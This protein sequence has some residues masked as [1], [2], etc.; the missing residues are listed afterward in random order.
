[1]KRIEV[2]GDSF[3]RGQQP[4][5]LVG[6]NYWP[7]SSPGCA[8]GGSG[9]WS[10]IQNYDSGVVEREIAAM[11]EIGANTLRVW[12]GYSDAHWSAANNL[13]REGRRCLAHLLDTCDRNG[14]YV[15]PT[16]GGAGTRWG[17]KRGLGNSFQECPS[18]VYTDQ[19]VEEQFLADILTLME[20]SEMGVRENVLAID[21][22][23]E[24]VFGIPTAKLEKVDATWAFGSG[25][26]DF[27]GSLRI[28]SAVTAWERWASNAWGSKAAAAA[29]FELKGETEDFPIPRAADFLFPGHREKLAASYQL[30]VN[31]C[32]NQHGIRMGDAIRS[33]YPQMLVTI[34]LGCGGTG[35]CFQG[36][37][38][39]E[40][41]QVMM[42]TQNVR[43][44]QDGLDF[45]CIHLYHSHGTD[46]SRMSFLRHF[47]GSSRPV[48]I[49][50]FAHIPRHIDPETGTGT[51]A[52]Q[53]A[54]AAFWDIVLRGT[55]RYNFAGALGCIY[56]DIDDDPFS[57]G[58]ACLGI[59]TRSGEPKRAHSIFKKWASSK[60]APVDCHPEPIP[61]DPG[62]YRN[63]VQMMGELYARHTNKETR[64]T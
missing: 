25:D 9:D 64:K 59:T 54:Q 22:A 30:F 27:E 43:E 8:P 12:F 32:L 46:L 47:L 10:A 18:R 20:E 5:R 50:E 41:R 29:A 1:M 26:L 11:A 4:F 3:W 52:E 13:T 6:F 62:A 17:V 40:A 45:V 53:E 44:M 2:K 61:Y 16:L 57:N 7:S 15:I 58:W 24:P 19:T 33:R 42:L 31:D 63:S 56:V 23:N 35:A 38:L 36:G 60:D 14:L 48:V 49:E 28:L 55:M 34:G 39:K 37:S 21:L 51:L